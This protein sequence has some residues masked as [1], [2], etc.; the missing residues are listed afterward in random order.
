MPGGGQQRGRLMHRADGLPEQRQRWEAAGSMCDTSTFGQVH[1][2]GD[3][4][5]A[6]RVRSTMCLRLV[7]LKTRSLLSVGNRTTRET[8]NCTTP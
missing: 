8:R 2:Q 7:D 6:S 1:R 3:A 5:G 4:V